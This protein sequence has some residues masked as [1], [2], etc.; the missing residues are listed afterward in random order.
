MEVV[1]SGRNYSMLSVETF[2]VCLCTHTLL[3]EA[4][5]QTTLWVDRL[6]H[7]TLISQPNIFLASSWLSGLNI[8]DPSF[9]GLRLVSTSFLFDHY[10]F[11]SM[12][13]MD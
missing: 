1:V 13:M 9:R 8:L 2:L 10:G 11:L 3:A 6:A 5:N 7:W 4:H 12:S